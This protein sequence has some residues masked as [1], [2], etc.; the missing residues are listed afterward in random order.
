MNFDGAV[1]GI[2][3]ARVQTVPQLPS[4]LAGAIQ[5]G[6]HSQARPGALL[7]VVNG[8]ARFLVTHGN[9]VEVAPEAGV[10]PDDVNIY[11]AGGVRGA[12]IHQRGELPLHAA[13]LVPPRGD[14]AVAI[15]GVS[16]MGK[17]TLAAELFHRG[18]SLLADDLTRVTADGDETLAW[19]GGGNIKLM[20]D[21]VERLG[22]QASTMR[23]VASVVDK[24]LLETTPLV[25][26]VRLGGVVSLH[27]SPPF[28]VHFLQQGEGIAL[29]SEQTFRAH[30]IAA[31]G[32]TALHMR[33]IMKVAASCWFATASGCRGSA[34]LADEIDRLCRAGTTV[35]RQ[36][37]LPG[38]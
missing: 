1:P 25:L 37:S 7:R 19:P 20:R 33:M 2:P 28:G 6:P 12:L 4:Q 5:V 24:V 23:R 27:R 30:Y 26:P 3:D 15:C 8:T 32:T 34:A 11:L 9:R 29:L 10:D 14:F 38:A 36:R 13:A 21:A 17:S 35:E 18:W 16:G 31:L 22:M